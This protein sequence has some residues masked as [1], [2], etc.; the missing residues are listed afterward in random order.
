[1]AT[2]I[3]AGL[4]ICKFDPAD[5]GSFTNWGKLV[6]TWATG[7]NRLGD[8]KDY[9]IPSTHEATS[10][11]GVMTKDQFVKML[12]MANVKMTI[13][14][15][16]KRFEFVQD[17]DSTVVVRIPSKKMIN[18]IEGKLEALVAS[19]PS[20]QYP[21]PQ[22]YTDAWPDGAPQKSLNHDDLLKM[23]CQRIGEYT[24]NTCG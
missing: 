15:R 2:D 13:P 6:K 22:F 12:A 9:S 14:D 7:E 4:D 18:G 17:D 23:H 19:A 11:I 10:P 5:T 3:M 8:G 1:M 20:A 16:I 24:I 21:L